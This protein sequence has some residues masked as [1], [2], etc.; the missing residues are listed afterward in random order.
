MVGKS[1][2]MQSR[3]V[4]S[5]FKTAA[6]V[7]E[8]NCMKSEDCE[9]IVMYVP[10]IYS[11]NTS[12]PKLGNKEGSTLLPKAETSLTEEGNKEMAVPETEKEDAISVSKVET[13]TS[14]KTNL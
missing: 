11:N 1:L 5:F 4:S 8:E 10:V 3:N 7:P 6:F 14:M 9:N 12:V 13:Y 2:R